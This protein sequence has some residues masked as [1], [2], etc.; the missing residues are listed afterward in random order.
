VVYKRLNPF[1][2]FANCD[3]GMMD[4]AGLEVY[5]FHRGLEW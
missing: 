4:F 1:M 2:I 3:E 5:S